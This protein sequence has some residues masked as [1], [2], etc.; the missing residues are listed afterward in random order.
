MKEKISKLETQQ[1][2]E[3]LC[4]DIAQPADKENLDLVETNKQLYVVG[5]DEKDDLVYQQQKG[6]AAILIKKLESLKIKADII[7]SNTSYLPVGIQK[8]SVSSK[9]SGQCPPDSLKNQTHLQVL[10][11]LSS[12]MQEMKS[13]NESGVNKKDD[14]ALTDDD[15]RNGNNDINSFPDT[16]ISENVQKQLPPSQELMLVPV[17][18][19]EAQPLN[20]YTGNDGLVHSSEE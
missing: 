2:I 6:Y 7:E 1:S 5:S 3:T 8:K 16:I 17:Q 11:Q 18:I 10:S 15:E 20:T 9:I 19:S 14:E 12:T 13:Q 4:K